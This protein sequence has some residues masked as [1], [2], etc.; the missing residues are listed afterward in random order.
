M[1]IVNLVF[2]YLLIVTN[3]SK[4]YNVCDLY[5]TL[6]FLGM[7]P[8]KRIYAEQ[9]VCA[10]D[11][12]SKL[13]TF[14]YENTKGIPRYGI[15]QLSGLEWCDNGRH[16]SPNKCNKSCNNFLDDD[17]TDD[18]LCVKKVVES[19]LDMRAWPVYKKY[20][21]RTLVNRYY[22]KCLFGRSGRLS[23]KRKGFRSLW[24]PSKDFRSE[25]VQ[26]K[27]GWLRSLPNA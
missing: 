25:K 19:T 24:I 3:K 10:A 7:D 5:Y 4:I 17:V 8:F 1:K 26:S 22:L 21:T 20:C 23:Q 27:G 14:Y 2:F 18:A 15:F 11:Y 12:S 13:D 16:K 9:Y 6:K